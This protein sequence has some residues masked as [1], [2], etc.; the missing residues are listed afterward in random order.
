METCF[1]LPAVIILSL[2]Y[3]KQGPM[4]HTATE[5]GNSMLSER[6]RISL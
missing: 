6:L 2:I 4:V 1:T 5:D 3:F